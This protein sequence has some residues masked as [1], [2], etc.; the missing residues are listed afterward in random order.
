MRT[1]LDRL[2]EPLMKDYESQ[3]FVV[4]ELEDMSVL[5]D[6][7][8]EILRLTAEVTELRWSLEGLEK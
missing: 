8:D 2:R 4:W 3:S 5:D 1:L 7:A 6:A